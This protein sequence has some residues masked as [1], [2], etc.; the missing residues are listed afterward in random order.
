MLLFFPSMEEVEMQTRRR[1]RRFQQ[2]MKKSVIKDLTRG[3]SLDHVLTSEDFDLDKETMKR[4]M[5]T[6]K[7]PKQDSAHTD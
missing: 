4:W 2:K 1:K 6:K 7:E 5:K 3:M